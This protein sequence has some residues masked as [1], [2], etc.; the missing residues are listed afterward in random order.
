[1]DSIFRKCKGTAGWFNVVRIARDEPQRYGK[2][3]E[4]LIAYDQTEEHQR[5]QSSVVSGTDMGRAAKIAEAN[6]ASMDGEAE[7]GF[8]DEIE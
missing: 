3:G 1:M 5:R 6:R 4:L 7:K 8:S 2:N